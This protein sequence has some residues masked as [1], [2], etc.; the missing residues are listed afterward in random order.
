[1]SIGYYPVWTAIYYSDHNEEH[2]ALRDYRFFSRIADVRTDFIF[3]D[4]PSKRR[5]T[6]GLPI[7]ASAGTLYFYGMDHCYHDCS[8]MSWKK[9]LKCY[10]EVNPD[11]SLN[12][13]YNAVYS[14]S[15]HD[16]TE[17][18]ARV[19]FWFDS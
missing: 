4:P 13:Y 12:D 15:S 2:L 16:E 10:L 3:G 6:K 17:F 1:M 11:F 8:Y 19:V 5:S 9:F 7:D 18:K 14:H